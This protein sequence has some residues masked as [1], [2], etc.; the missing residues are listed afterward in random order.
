MLA[1]GIE[2]YRY[3]ERFMHQ[4]VF[5]VDDRVS[6]IGTANLDNR[7]FRL[8]FEVTALV[9]DHGFNDQVEQMLLADF[10]RS[11]KM[12]LSDV[13]GKP[14]WFKAAARAAYLTAPLQ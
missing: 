14:T 9:V 6:A 10:E 12:T 4:K 11:R 1:S 5:L 7:S 2:I 3:Q 13:E 8:N